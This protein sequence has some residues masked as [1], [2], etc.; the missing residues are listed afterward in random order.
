MKHIV[1]LVG[2]FLFFPNFSFA[3]QLTD[4]QARS[5]ISV[6]QSSPSVPASAFTEL[7]TAFS[8][9]TVTQAN[10]LINVVQQSP[11][12]PADPFVNLL[13][14]FTVDTIMVAPSNPIPTQPVSVPAPVVV[15]P[16][17]QPIQESVAPVL[18]S[19]APVVYPPLKK[20]TFSFYRTAD[21]DVFYL[22]TNHRLVIASTT[23]PEGASIGNILVENKEDDGFF[24]KTHTDRIYLNKFEINGLQL[25]QW[26][27]TVM[28][29]NGQTAWGGITVSPR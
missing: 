12:T 2:M 7:I 23:L 16:A 20:G 21:A 9:I 13:I 10:S 19:V 26:K 25:G 18:G 15:Q 17:P 4:A 6:V 1:V 24:D 5:L 8:N 14:S 22:T 11:S 28:D 27:V 29:E 3:A